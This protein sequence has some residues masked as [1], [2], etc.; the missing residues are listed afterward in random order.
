MKNK[1]I[2][3]CLITAMLFSVSPVFAEDALQESGTTQITENEDVNVTEDGRTYITINGVEYDITDMS[4]A[5]IDALR[6]SN[7]TSR[8]AVTDDS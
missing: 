5:E 6:Q 3:L 1:L 8:D 2:S 7:D 4:A